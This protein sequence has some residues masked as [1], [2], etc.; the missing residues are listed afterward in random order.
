MHEYV[1]ILHQHQF[2]HSPN[3][4]NIRNFPTTITR[5]KGVDHITASAVTYAELLL[6]QV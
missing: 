3:A 1:R 5:K 6:V 4:R 2:L